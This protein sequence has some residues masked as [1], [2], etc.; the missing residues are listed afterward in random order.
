MHARARASDEE[1]EE[2]RLISVSAERERR[3]A[4]FVA[5]ERAWVGYIEAVVGNFAFVVRDKVGFARCGGCVTRGWVK[6]IVT[7]WEYILERNTL[8]LITKKSMWLC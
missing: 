8:F 1:E 4:S 7:L 5:S 3:F 2:R 6:I